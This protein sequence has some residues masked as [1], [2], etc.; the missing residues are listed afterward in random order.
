MKDAISD[1]LSLGPGGRRWRVLEAFAALM[2]FACW[3]REYF[4]GAQRPVSVL[5]LAR[6]GLGCPWP[7]FFAFALVSG[8][9]GG[10]VTSAAMGLGM[11]AR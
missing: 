2:S 11:G 10:G 5:Y 7:L 8:G 4:A 9:A 6:K 3:R 1:E